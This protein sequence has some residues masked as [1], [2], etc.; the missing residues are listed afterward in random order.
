[1]TAPRVIY[2]AGVWDLLHRGHLNLLHKAARLGD[3][4]VVGVIS[5]S[6]CRAY[7]GVF[8]AEHQSKRMHAL[9]RIG[10]VDM[11]IHQAGTD[12]T[13]NLER[14]RPDVMVHADDWLKLRE[15]HEALERLGVEWVLVP[16]TPGIS[17]TMLRDAITTEGG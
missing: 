12:P 17:S 5:D 8:P 9:D 4:L 16:Y 13:D 15:G 6:G 11:V 2:T 7:K 10:C 14:I 1:M 3:M